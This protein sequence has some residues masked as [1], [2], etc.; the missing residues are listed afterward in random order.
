MKTSA[1]TLLV[2]GI[3]L[4]GMGAGFVLMP[5]LLL[6]PLGFPPTTEVWSRV[7]GALALL[8]A[9]YY[10]QAARANLRPLI[11]W[12][13]TGRMSVFVLFTLFVLA[14]WASPMLAVLGS[15]DLVMALWTAWALRKESQPA[16]G[17]V[18]G[19]AKQSI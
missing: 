17:S 15:F 19:T 8:L 2:F 14:G 16:Q 9:F 12:T 1:K 4:I 18:K 6:A 7:V 11:E 13:V 3:Y 5:N 10:I